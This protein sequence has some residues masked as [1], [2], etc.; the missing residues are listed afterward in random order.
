MLT[1]ERVYRKF[2]FTFIELLITIIV[3]GIALSALMSALSTSVIQGATPL[4]EGKALALGQ[5][6]MDEIVP[7]RFDD[8][9]PEAGGEVAAGLSPCDISNEGQSRNLFDDV[10]DYNG[11]NDQPPTLLQSSFNMS[12]YANYA[13]SISVSCAGDELGLSA[14]HLAKRITLNIIGP[15]GEVR[16]LSVYRGNF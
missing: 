13:V 1:G 4:W 16:T 8:Q 10:D 12:S 14:L 3:I 5:A 15:S 2:G 11:V 7:L 6:Y 9:S